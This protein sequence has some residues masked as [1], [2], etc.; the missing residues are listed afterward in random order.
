MN[1]HH[2]VCDDDLT[3]WFLIMAHEMNGQRGAVYDAFPVY[4][5]AGQVRR[6]RNIVD[7]GRAV[8][9]V[10]NT[11]L[12][13]DTGIGNEHVDATPFLPY[14]PEEIR[15]GSIRLDG[16]LNEYHRFCTRVELLGDLFAECGSSPCHCHSITST[17][18]IFCEVKTNSTLEIAPLSGMPKKFKIEN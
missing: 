4:L 11:A 18:K 5:G 2:A 3:T 9:K 17:V 14:R 10:V 6:V 1:S 15:L 8:T 12:V 13:D 16:A 7:V